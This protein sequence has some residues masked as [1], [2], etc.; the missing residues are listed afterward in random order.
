MKLYLGKQKENII[1]LILWVIV[2]LAPIVSMQVRVSH[3]NSATFDWT[4]VL[5]VWKVYALYLGIFLIHNF[6]L[7]PLLVERHR[8]LMYLATTM[9]L[10]GVFFIFQCSHRPMRLDGPKPHEMHRPMGPP[11]GKMHAPKIENCDIDA[12][13]DLPLPPPMDESFAEPPVDGGPEPYGFADRQNGER[14][15]EKDGMYKRQ[16]P[17]L[18]G[19]GDIFG[20]LFLVLL[21]GMNIG[22]KLFFKYDEDAKSMALL[23]KQS[24]QQQLEHLKYQLNPHFFMNTLNNIHALVDIDPEQSKQ[25]IVGLSRLMRYVLYEG[26]KDMV[27]LKRD[28]DFIKDYIDLMKIRYTDKVDITTDIPSDLPDAEVPPMIFIT[29]VENAFKHGI[30]Y[31]QKS[32]INIEVR[33]AGERL[34]FG[35]RNSIFGSEDNEQGGVGLANVRQR[36]GL[37]FGKDYAIDIQEGENKYT[38]GIDIPL[39]KA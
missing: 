7:A 2:F 29:F 11:P 9:C 23:E 30:S 20:T 3:H 24:L 8:R 33:T 1:Y 31:E 18:F 25:T 32:F 13:P 39:K 38:V 15:H 5:N 10:I 35:C 22:V 21:L 4:E 16:P 36:L 6:I 12:L 27:P 34:F 26:S 19:E 14:P 37:L 28:I 17:L